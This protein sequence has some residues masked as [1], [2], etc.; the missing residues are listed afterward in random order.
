MT[1][2]AIAGVGAQFKRGDG[3]SNESFTAV[4]EVNSIA[5]PTMTRNF[6]DVTSL[7]STGGY[8]E[9]ITGFRDAG[10]ITLNMNFTRDGYDAMKDDF[11]S[12]SSRNYQ[13][14]MPDTGETTF[15]FA[16]LVTSIPLDIP[17]DDKITATVTLKLSGQV[18]MSS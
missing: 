4:S 3:E 15:E 6:I 13:I 9:F 5:G 8:R 17:T 18:T 16:A 12:D 1:T 14:V 11:E 7:D 10:E 2:E